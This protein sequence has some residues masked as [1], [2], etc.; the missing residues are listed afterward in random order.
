MKSF[1]TT[2]LTFIFPIFFFK[3]RA[4]LTPWAGPHPQPAAVEG[5]VESP[6][7]RLVPLVSLGVAP[8]CG[9]ALGW[10][11]HGRAP[12]RSSPALE[13]VRAPTHFFFKIS[14]IYMQFVE[15]FYVN[16]SLYYTYLSSRYFFNYF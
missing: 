3:L 12:V 4:S 13:G 6:R 16:F 14:P 8:R 5:S 9:L 1:D 10:R 11:M 2:V 15:H 7:P